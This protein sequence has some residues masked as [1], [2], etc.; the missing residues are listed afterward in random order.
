MKPLT[1]IRS[2]FIMA[3]VTVC[4]HEAH[5]LVVQLSGVTDHRSY[6]LLA[7]CSGTLAWLAHVLG[8]SS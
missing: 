1:L 7:L 4:F 3:L 8:S 6:G 2:I 5:D